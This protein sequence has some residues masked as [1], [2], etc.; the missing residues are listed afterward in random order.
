MTIFRSRYSI[1]ANFILFFLIISFITR[2]ILLI[3]EGIKRILTLFPFLRIYG[4]GL[5]FDISVALFSARLMPFISCCFRS[6][7]SIPPQPHHYLRLLFC[8]GAHSSCFPFSPSLCSGMN[9]KA[10]SRLL[11]LIT[12]C[13][14]LR[15]LN[16][17]Q[18]CPLPWLISGMVLLSLLVGFIFGNGRFST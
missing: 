14:H 15:S 5:V 9:L 6:A 11:P 1:L 17:N 7:G 10:G 13:I 8:S 4:K 16:I 12:W 3:Q 2:T 18:S